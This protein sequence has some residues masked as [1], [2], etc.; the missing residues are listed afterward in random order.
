MNKYRDLL[1]AV[2]GGFIAA[3]A[4]PNPIYSGM[5]W[6]GGFLGWICLIPLLLIAPQSTK[7]LWRLGFIYGFV[8]FGLAVIWIA[9]MQSMA[10]LGPLAWFLLTAYLALYPGLFLISYHYLRARGVPWWLTAA[11]GW[12][13]LEFARNYIISG[14]PWDSLGY[15]QYGIP[16]LM[17]VLPFSG[18]WGLSFTVAMGNCL[19]YLLLIW[20]GSLFFH[21]Q[22]WLV[23]ERE[24]LLH[25]RG[26]LIL[27]GGLILLILTGTIMEQ[28][29]LH[30]QA[31][32]P[33]MRVA[34]M[35]GNI[36][37]NT[38]WDFDFQQKTLNT[39][40]TLLDKAASSHA[41]LAVWPETAFPGIF[42]YDQQLANTVRLWSR[43]LGIYQLV[44]ADEIKRTQKEYLYYNAMVLIDNTGKV[45][46]ST[47]KRHLVPFGEYVPYKD[48][49]L[50]FVHKLVRR[51]GGAGFTPGTTRNLL[52]MDQPQPHTMVGGIICFESLFPQYTRDLTKRGARLLAVI[53]YDTWFGHSSAPAQHAI[54][55]AFRAAET[56]RA[57]VRAAATGISCIFDPAGRLMAKIDLDKEGVLVKD[58]P[59]PKTVTFYVRFGD[60]IVALLGLLMLGFWSWGK[61]RLK[62]KQ[63]GGEDL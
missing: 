11:G 52:P 51:Y 3:M 44:G 56:N 60:W 27:A 37:Q 13:I 42:N 59:L 9:P 45:R 24:V 28:S 12:T 20:L 32:A 49:I 21:R 39:Y 19:I 47:A 14:F 18:I 2:G 58:V 57:L 50:F 46:G 33:V 41:T 62:N 36:N 6:K 55:S 25:S 30:H 5:D 10:P 17:A 63:A 38:T 16:A 34:S 8:Y 61:W 53:T 1:L 31:K 40:K 23:R 29:R 54:F 7:R 15:S 22:A 4:F 43:I 26:N 35:Q 48:S